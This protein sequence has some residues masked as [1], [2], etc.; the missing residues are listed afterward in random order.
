M[1]NANLVK[2]LVKVGQSSVTV[3]YKLNGI[4]C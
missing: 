4:G 3:G 2:T 1:K